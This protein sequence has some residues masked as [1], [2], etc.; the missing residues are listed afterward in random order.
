MRASASDTSSAAALSA[1]ALDPRLHDPP[2]AAL[3][4]H[5]RVWFVKALEIAP[6]GVAQEFLRMVSLQSS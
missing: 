6:D 1:D 3:L 5:A 4:R 2:N